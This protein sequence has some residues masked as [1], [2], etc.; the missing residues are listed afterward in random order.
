[1]LRNVQ[2]HIE[3]AYFSLRGTDLG[4]ELH[5]HPKTGFSRIITFEGQST[6]ICFTHLQTTFLLTFLCSNVFF[7][8]LFVTVTIF[9]CGGGRKCY[10]RHICFGTYGRILIRYIF[11]K[12]NIWSYQFILPFIPTKMGSF[13]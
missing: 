8:T 1:M 2:K 11:L 9:W 6:K 10:R 5:G 13:W 3:K 4:L 7:H 12:R